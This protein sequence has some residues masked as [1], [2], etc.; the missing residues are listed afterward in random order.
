MKNIVKSVPVAQ[1]HAFPNNP[2]R[3]VENEEFAA[4]EESIQ[5]YGVI[6]PLVIRPMED[7]QYEIISGHRRA[8]AC[9]K[10]GIETVS[11]LI[12]EMDRNAAVIALV[13]SN[14]H[15]EHILP[16]EKAFAYKMKLEAI[17]RKAGRPA[18]NS[19]QVVGNFE[20]ADL[21]GDKESGRQVQ[22]YIR[23]TE[24][25]PPILDMVDEGRVGFSPAVE[26]SYLTEPEQIYLFDTMESEEATPSLAQANRM[27]RLSQDGQLDGDVI[28][29]IM[30]EDKPN[31]AEKVSFKA[32]RFRQYFPQSYTSRQMEEKIIELLES[33]QRHRQ[34]NRDAR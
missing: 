25:Y 12:C 15:R 23:L 30:D 14:L 26:I 34:Q 29:E 18:I 5:S 8:L 21:V 11:A 22:R 17:K 32:E 16:S 2:F 9:R 10:A 1:L 13:D 31:Q 20:S 19:R 28:S 3:V 4:L 6:S 7:G 33:W 27:K 24:L